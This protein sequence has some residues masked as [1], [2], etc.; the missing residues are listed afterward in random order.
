MGVSSFRLSER[1]ITRAVLGEQRPGDKQDI[2]RTLG[3]AAHVPAIPC[4]SIADQRLGAVAENIYQSIGAR[5]IFGDRVPVTAR[6]S[7]KFHEKLRRPI[8]RP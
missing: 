7:R 8:I 3:Q 1:P 5:S 6:L 2:R 4:R